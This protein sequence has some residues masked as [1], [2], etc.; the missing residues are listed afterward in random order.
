MGS[1]AERSV[2]GI[3]LHRS[4]RT[5]CLLLLLLSHARSSRHLAA[6]CTARERTACAASREGRTECRRLAKAA[7]AGHVRHAAACSAQ[8]ASW[9][10]ERRSSALKASELS[11]TCTD[12]AAITVQF[13]SQ[14]QLQCARAEWV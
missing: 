13:V 9:S 10:A 8:L 14:G 2:D 7:Q 4:T 3:G 6:G 5:R 12:R 1:D 11:A